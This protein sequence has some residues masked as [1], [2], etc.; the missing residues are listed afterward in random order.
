MTEARTPT[1]KPKKKRDN[2]Q[3]PPKTLITQRL[4]SDLGRS[5]GIMTATQLVC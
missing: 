2:T 4:R 5:V 3:M 1:E